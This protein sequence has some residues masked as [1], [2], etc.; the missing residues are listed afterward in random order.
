MP[1]IGKASRV[2]NIGSSTKRSGGIGSST[3]SY[4]SSQHEDLDL[5]KTEYPTT[6]TVAE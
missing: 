1:R 5:A 2:G 4:G 3:T 6:T